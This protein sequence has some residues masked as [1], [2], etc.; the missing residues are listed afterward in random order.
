MATDVKQNDKHKLVTVIIQNED[1]FEDIINIITEIEGSNITITEAS[2][3]SRYLYHM[4]LFTSFMQTDR[5]DFCRIITATI[6]SEFVDNLTN[7]LTE[8]IEEKNE[9]G[10]MFFIQNIE[11][12]HGS[13]EI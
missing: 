12:L 9:N 7:D 1:K 2:N 6:E 11:H 3:A 4:P 8:I 13:L 5:N 10:I